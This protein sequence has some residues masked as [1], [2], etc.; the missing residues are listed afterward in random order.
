[1]LEL[2]VAAVFTFNSAGRVQAVNEVLRHICG[3]MKVPHWGSVICHLTTSGAL[4]VDGPA[5]PKH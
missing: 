4:G 3:C 2:S 1:M 5:S